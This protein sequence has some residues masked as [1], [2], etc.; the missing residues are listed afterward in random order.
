L[1]FFCLSWAK[2]GGPGILLESTRKGEG[3]QSKTVVFPGVTIRLYISVQIRCGKVFLSKQ[4]SAK[5]S[6]EALVS[7]WQ[8]MS[9]IVRL[10]LQKRRKVM[11]S[12]EF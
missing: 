7:I 5:S 9:I 1:R 11:V 3:S 12:G 4:Y 6:A 10:T 2:V 8:K